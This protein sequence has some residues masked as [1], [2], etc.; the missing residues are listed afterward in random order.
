M[1]Y[2]KRKVCAPLHVSLP[3]NTREYPY[4]TQ[5]GI[6]NLGN[7]VIIKRTRL[8]QQIW[9]TPKKISTSK[10]RLK[11]YRAKLILVNKI[12]PLSLSP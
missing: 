6:R 11:A 12:N 3:Y 2:Y 9:K 5:P 8:D 4:N 1:V 7:K 10:H